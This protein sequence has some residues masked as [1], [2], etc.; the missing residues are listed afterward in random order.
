MYIKLDLSDET[1]IANALQFTKD[2]GSIS[3]FTIK[4]Q[5]ISRTQGSFGGTFG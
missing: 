2:F 5:Q 1:E 3:E 4:Q